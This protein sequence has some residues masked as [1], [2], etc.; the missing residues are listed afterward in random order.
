MLDSILD[1]VVSVAMIAAFAWILA[2][3]VMMIRGQ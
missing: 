2:S 1:A 3:A